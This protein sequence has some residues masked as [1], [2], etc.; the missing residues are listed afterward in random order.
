[1][2]VRVVAGLMAVAMAFGAAVDPAAS[3][4]TIKL[5]QSGG[6]SDKV[7]IPP[8]VAEAPRVSKT[9]ECKQ[10]SPH[11]LAKKLVK[12]EEALVGVEAQLKGLPVEAP[13]GET[14]EALQ[15]RT[16]LKARLEAE[17]ASL[18]TKIA[19]LQP[20]VAASGIDLSV[21]QAERTYKTISSNIKTKYAPQAAELKAKMSAPG[22]SFVEKQQLK[23]QKLE[24]ELAAEKEKLDWLAANF[25]RTA[26][27]AEETPIEVP[28]AAETVSEE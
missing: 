16:A 7:E 23:L 14:P 20:V 18:R 27:T 1:M 15:A 26:P 6:L 8:V 3:A 4:T 25:P 24:L 12:S 2:R 13:V 11:K 19:E 22:I 10:P 5:A 17:A 28:E 21:V 9:K